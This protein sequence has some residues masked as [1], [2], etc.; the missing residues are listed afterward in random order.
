MNKDTHKRNMKT[1]N[2]YELWKLPIEQQESLLGT[3]IGYQWLG[4][5]LKGWSVM[6]HLFPKG[7]VEVDPREGRI[8]VPRG[9]Q[10]HLQPSL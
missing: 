6:I 7:R 4:H 8:R 2:F 5:A 10:P 1:D 3:D 9:H